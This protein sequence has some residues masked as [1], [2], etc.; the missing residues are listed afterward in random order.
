MAVDNHERVSDFN[1]IWGAFRQHDVA[2]EHNGVAGKT[3]RFLFFDIDQLRH[4]RANGTL[5]IFIKRRWKPDR[6]AIGQRTKAG[7][8]MVKTRVDQLDRDD[9]AAKHVRDRAMRLNVAAELVTAKKSVAAEERVTFPFEI[10]I[11]RQPKNFITVLFH[12]TH[13]IRRFTGPFLMAKITRNKFL[14]DG[15]PGVGSE[16]HVGQFRLRRHQLDLRRRGR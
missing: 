14:A 3:L 9:E 2:L 1:E 8:E 5:T 10:Q 16:H 15:E 6:T 4:V 7:V 12:P 11:F 13:E